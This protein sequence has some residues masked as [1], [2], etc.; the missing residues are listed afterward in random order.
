[1]EYDEDQDYVYKLYSETAQILPM[2]CI[3]KKRSLDHYMNVNERV[4]QGTG[5]IRSG[6]DSIIFDDKLYGIIGKIK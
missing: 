4:Y 6:K 2:S 1:L 3:M 5:R